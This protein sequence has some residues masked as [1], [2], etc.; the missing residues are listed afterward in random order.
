[1]SGVI[2]RSARVLEGEDL[3]PVENGAVVVC[4]GLIEFAG[5]SREA[6]E[7]YPAYTVLDLGQVVLLP[8]L[9]DC[10]S[11]TSMD[12]KVAGHLDMMND[13]APE[14]TVRAVRYAREDIEAGITTARI[15]GDKHYVDVAV[16]AAINAGEIPGP[17]LLVAG[18]GMRAV[19]GHGFVGVP[20]TGADELRKTCRENMLRKVDWLKIFV[21]AGAPPVGS[22]HIPSFLSLEEI[23]T[24]SGEA[25]RFG[26]RTSAHCIGGGGLTDCVQAG[27]DVIDHAYCATDD[28]LKLI[29]DKGRSICLTPSVFMDLERN[30]KNPPQVARNTELGRQRVIEVMHKIVTSGV[31]YAIGSDA[32][33][34]CLALEAAYTVE[35]GASAREALLGLTVKAAALCGVGDRG[36]LAAGKLADIIAAEGDPRESIENLKKIVFVMKGGI[37]YR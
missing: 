27:I 10:H 33:H 22:A 29:R 4:G 20:H 30:T 8:G 5:P 15:L 1:M 14:L 6:L 32:L 21:T 31:F 3:N 18:I 25:K 16:R 36:C 26:I 34:G 24:V 13:T 11:H 28:D 23:E 7:L 9:I 35:L 12:A 19:H 2:L 37:R 17:R